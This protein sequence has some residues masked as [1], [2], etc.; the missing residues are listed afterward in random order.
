MTDTPRIIQWTGERCVPWLPDAQ[1]VYEHLHRYLWAAPLVA[2]RRVLDLASGEG[3]GAAI[4]AD[5]AAEVVGVEIDP[6]A[7]EHSRLRYRA[8]NLEFTAGDARDLSRFD[9]QSIDAV[10]AFEMIE[11]LSDEDQQQVLA[12]VARVLAPDGLL[13]MSTPDRDAYAEAT[14]DTNPFHERELTTD[15]F[16]ALV[17]SRFAHLAHWA[18][19]PATGSVL[20]AKGQARPVDDPPPQNVFVRRRGDEWVVVPEP[21]ALYVIAVASNS[22]LP[23]IASSSN[24][25]DCDLEAVTELRD[26]IDRLNRDVD[27]Q[28]RNA[29]QFSDRIAELQ[30]ELVAAESRLT[31]TR[32]NLQR[33]EESVT[34]QLFQRVRALV[35][36]ALGGEGSSAVRRLEAGLRALGR[37]LLGR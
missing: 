28:W 10:T 36:K 6:Q 12:E 15:E 25:V 33:I 29:K 1:L 30:Q 5:A 11:H 2:D 8:R 35:F 32:A 17:G 18:Q 37:L 3:Y 13:I 31:A 22:P 26:T 27:A 4:L 20:S 9:S 24:L 19:R 14:G 23:P 16:L 21:A 7:V 34:W